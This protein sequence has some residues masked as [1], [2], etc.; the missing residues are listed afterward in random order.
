MIETGLY[1]VYMVQSCININHFLLPSLPHI[2]FI[3]KLLEVNF[4]R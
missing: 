4:I 3:Y 1:V 2:Y